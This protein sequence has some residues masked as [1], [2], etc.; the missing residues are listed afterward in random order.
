MVGVTWT[1]PCW[2]LY[3]FNN[4]PN[5]SEV[6]SLLGDNQ[7]FANSETGAVLRN[8]FYHDTSTDHYGD[9]W[10]TYHYAGSD[11]IKTGWFESWWQPLLYC[12]TVMMPLKILQS[13]RSRLFSQMGKTLDKRSLW[14]K[15]TGENAYDDEGVL[16]LEYRKVATYQYD[17]KIL[18]SK[19]W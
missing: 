4:R 14:I 19:I 1:K 10:N 15:R 2:D 17:G 18:G 11:G 9:F 16:C 6:L 7:Y 8:A 5:K 13:S 3:Y 12:I